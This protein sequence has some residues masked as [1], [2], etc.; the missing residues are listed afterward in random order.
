MA[1]VTAQLLFVDEPDPDAVRLDVVVLDRVETSV[2]PEVGAPIAFGFDL[3]GDEHQRTR[4]RTVLANW[5]RRSATIGMAVRTRH[6]VDEVELRSGV[7]SLLLA[8]RVAHGTA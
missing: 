3:P 4:V 8:L 6:G 5:S 1:L 2:S 7:A